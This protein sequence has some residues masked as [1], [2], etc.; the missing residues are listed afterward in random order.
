MPPSLPPSLPSLAWEPLGGARWAWRWLP[1]LASHL[2]GPVLG[3]AGRSSFPLCRHLPFPPHVLQRRR[4]APGR[5]WNRAC[6]AGG[7][8][9]PEVGPSAPHL[10][11][12][13]PPSCA[14]SSPEPT[15]LG[16]K[17]RKRAGRDR[18]RRGSG[19]RR[20]LGTGCSN[21]QPQGRGGKGATPRRKCGGGS[22]GPS[23][24]GGGGG[25]R[26]RT[27]LQASFSVQA[28]QWLEVLEA[29]SPG[30]EAQLSSSQ[31]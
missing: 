27:H 24:P 26:D 8:S 16:N 5:L 25:C 20:R 13:P 31:L 3:W 28:R 15:S 2:S 23:E 30:G 18:E 21:L 19:D 29:S 12:A 22:G 11:P 9:W 7:G 1:G 17:S 6:R 10:P 14:A 4:L